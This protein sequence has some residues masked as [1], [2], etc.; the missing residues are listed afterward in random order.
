MSEM[1]YTSRNL[2]CFYE[3]FQALAGV[4]IEIEQGDT[5]G[6]VGPNGAGKTTLL[7]VLGG[8][9][10]NWTG[11]VDFKGSSLPDWNRKHFAR[12]VAYVPQQTHIIFPYSVREVVLMGRIPHQDG[13]FFE[14]RKDHLQVEEALRLTDSLDLGDRYFNELSGGERQLVILASA[15]AQEPQVLLLDEPTVFLDLKHQLM[16][17]RILKDLHSTQQLTLVL[18][19]HDLNLAQSFCDRVFLMKEGHLIAE[20]QKQDTAELT[21][22]ADLIEKVFD[23]RAE[24]EGSREARIILSFG[25]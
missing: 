6:I 9:L 8:L 14:S 18:V 12:Q 19:T 2:S 17:F 7:K 11:D 25:R 20:C 5:V 21:L 24:I 10:T 15:L 1:L 16:I 13:S 22:P 3:R 23:V 4:N